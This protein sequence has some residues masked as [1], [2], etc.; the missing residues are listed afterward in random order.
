MTLRG[1]KQ[2]AT[3]SGGMRSRFSKVRK[4]AGVLFQFRDIRARA[5][6][7]SADLAHSQRLLGHQ[8]REMTEHYVKQRIGERVLPRR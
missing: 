8:R 2:K 4:T 5:A 6:T 1:P 3:A 7:D